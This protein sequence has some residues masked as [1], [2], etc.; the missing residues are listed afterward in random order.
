MLFIYTVFYFLTTPHKL[1]CDSKRELVSLKIKTEP[2]SHEVL[3]L[4][5]IVHRAWKGKD[6]S[7][8]SLNVGKLVCVCECV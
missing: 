2:Q 3:K 8:S 7:T 6:L 1:P 5:Y 4:D